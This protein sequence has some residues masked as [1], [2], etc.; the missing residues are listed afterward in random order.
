MI[1]PELLSGTLRENLDPFHQHDDAVL[2]DA[3]RSAGL[4]SLQAAD[5]ESKITLDSVIAGGGNNMSVGQRQII[6][7]ARALVRGSKVLILDEGGSKL[8][9]SS[10]IIKVS[11]IL[12]LPLPSVGFQT[13]PRQR[14]NR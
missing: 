5:S 3:L 1:Q 9:F 7:L 12:Q 6:A 4:D 10:L 14:S 13:C 8:V 11:A 2:N